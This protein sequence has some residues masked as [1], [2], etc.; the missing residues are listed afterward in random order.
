ML[1]A[2]RLAHAQLLAAKIRGGLI[3]T[4]HDELLAEVAEADA[5]RAR[6]ILQAVMIEAFETTFPGAPSTGVAV[7]TIGH[8]W[9]ELKL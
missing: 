6:D 2:I 3:A 4:I 8:N 9:A 1:R 5:E 7:G